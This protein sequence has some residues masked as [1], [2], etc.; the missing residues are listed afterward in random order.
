MKRYVEHGA[1]VALLV[2]LAFACAV[3]ALARVK[4]GDPE[5]TDFQELQKEWQ[6]GQYAPPAGTRIQRPADVPDIF[7]PGAVLTV[8]NVF[9]KCTNYGLDGNPFTNLSSDPSGQWPGASSIEYLNYIGVGVGAVNPFATDP[10]AIRRVSYITEWR[11]PSL[12]PAIRMYRSYDGILNGSRF[13]NDDGDVDPLT[14]EQRIDEDFLDGQDNDGDGKVDED[15]GAIGQQ[16]YTCVMRDDTP[17]A[18]NAA[19]SERHVPLG[20]EMLKSDWAYSIPGYTDFNVIQYDIYNRSGHTLDSVV[21]GFRTDMDCGPTDK[22]SYWTDDFNLPYYPHGDFMIRTKDSDLRLQPANDRAAGVN[23]VN[24]DSALCPRFRIRVNGWSTVDDDGDL[25]RT[26]GIGTVMLI[27]HTIDPTGVNGPSRVGLRAFRSF[28]GGTPYTQGGAPTIDQQRFEFMTSHDNI[29]QETGWITLPTGDQKG[30]YNEWVSIGPWLHLPDGGHLQ[31]TLAFGVRLGTMQ[32]AQ[33]YTADYDRAVDPTVGAVTNGADLVAKYPSLDNAIA[34]QVAF[35]GGYEVRFWPYLTDFHGRETPVKAPPGELLYLIGCPTRDFDARPVNDRQYTWFDFDC[36]YCT[37]AYSKSKGGLFHRTWLA[38]APPPSPAT[39]MGTAYNYTDNPDRRFIPAGDR[40]VTIA[41]DNLS[42]VT[43]DPKTGQF[44]FR[45]YKVWKVS[46]WQRPVG[47]GGPYEDDWTLIGEFRLFD[48]KANNAVMTCPP[49]SIGPGK[50]CEGMAVGDTLWPKIYIPQLDQRVPIKLYRGDLWDRQSGIVLH[51]DWSVLC[52]GWPDCKTQLGFPLGLTSGARVPH[53]VYPVGRYHIVD[54]QVK[55]GFIYFYSVTAFDSSGVGVGKT[56]LASRRSAVESE[57]VV[58]QASADTVN[59]G[60]KV[61]V[62][63]NPYRGARRIAD[64]PSSWDLTPNASD[65]TG[66]HIDFFGLP[67]GEWKIKIFT[68]S[69]DYVAEIKS[70]DAVNES[71]RPAVTDE[72]GV[73]RH[74]FNRQADNPNDG[75]ARWNL[76]SR[77]GQDVVSGIYL[78][79]VEVGGSVKHRGKFVIIR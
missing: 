76:I 78:F 39:N 61:W 60:S 33:Q 9:M 23:D 66:T 50:A 68:V 57:G 13:V 63:P 6:V 75:E 31:A 3:P 17:Q 20:L 59:K 43:P 47:S 21:I 64:R 26:L 28:S 2:V 19:A 41:W 38:E 53:T 42:E 14:G 36:D 79:T 77:N 18:I 37:G 74:G 29:D 45:G 48:A 40:Q 71:I 12:D 49:E 62:V 22:A 54:N 4:E 1:R 73:S 44:D 15:F 8:G 52:S 24:A 35:E 65:P 30:D 56:E 70:T 25:N 72:S 16:M 67:R 46:D 7:G 69:G 27:D 51:P 11:P 58:P 34:A 55:N 5:Y 10:N 32:L